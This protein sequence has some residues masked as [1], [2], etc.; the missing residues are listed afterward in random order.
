[1]HEYELGMP[2][3]LRRREDQ[4][5]EQAEAGR[6]A[7]DAAK[8]LAAGRPEAVRPA[9]MLHLQRAAGNA[10][11]AQLLGDE[12]QAESPVKSVVGRSGGEPLDAGI[13]QRMEASFG[14]DFSDV[15]VHSGGEAASSARAVDAHAYTVGNEVVLGEGH[16]PGS[17][18]HERTMAHELTHV[19]QQ[20]SGPVEGTEAPGGIRLSSPS[21]RFERAAEA[22][23]D[24]VMG[25]G[26]PGPATTSAAPA[27]QALAAQRDEGADEAQALAIQRQ[28]TPEEKEK[29]EEEALEAKPEEKPEELEAKPEE[30][31]KPEEL[32]AKPEEE[33]KEELQALAIQRQ[34]EPTEEPIEA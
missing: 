21:D 29:E 20:R 16:G 27:A 32:E 25:G 12:Q 11:I 17:A 30:E 3:R 19:L 9:A 7:A 22:T 26:T 6:E 15:R 14:A 24:V 31:E 8:A 4:A 5:G 13:R 28:A 1:M 18:S 34:E 2:E 33:E 10:G 23:A